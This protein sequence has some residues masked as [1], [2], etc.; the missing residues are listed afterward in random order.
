M[1]AASASPASDTTLRAKV[2][3]VISLYNH[4]RRGPPSDLIVKTKVL[5]VDVEADTASSAS[6]RRG[7]LFLIET[8]SCMV[9]YQKQRAR[10]LNL[11]IA[12]APSLAII[13]AG[14][15]AAATRRM[16]GSLLVAAGRAL[17]V[18]ITIR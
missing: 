12:E 1:Q 18:A 15:A 11:V 5:R 6:G 16:C 7:R 2:Y 10:V 3:K 4:D 13:R 8:L 9:T 17:G 14:A